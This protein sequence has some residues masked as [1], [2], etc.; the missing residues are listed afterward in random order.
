VKAR[1]PVVWRKWRLFMKGVFFGRE[2]SAIG[3][4]TEKTEYPDGGEH[5]VA[6]E[7]GN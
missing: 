2:E 3:S 4:T 5:S 1:P 6:P 7:L